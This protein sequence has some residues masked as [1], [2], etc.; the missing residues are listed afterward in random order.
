VARAGLGVCFWVSVVCDVWVV[1]GAMFGWTCLWVTAFSAVG[2]M[3]QE[4]LHLGVDVGCSRVS[5]DL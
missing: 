5:V 2:V 4:W 3:G 1:G